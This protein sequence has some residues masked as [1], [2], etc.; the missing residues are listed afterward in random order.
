MVEVHTVGS[1]AA[2]AVEE[3]KVELEAGEEMAEEHKIEAGE[4]E[5]LW[6][7]CI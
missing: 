7:G 3:H 6:F 1:E 5:V 2:E 4:V